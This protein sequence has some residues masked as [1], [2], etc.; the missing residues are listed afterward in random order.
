MAHVPLQADPRDADK[1]GVLTIRAAL[2]RARRHSADGNGAS[3]FGLR[4]FAALAAAL[5]VIGLLAN[6]L[7]TDQLKRRQIADYARTQQ[8]DVKSFEAIGREFRDPKVAVREVA[9]VLNAIGKRPGTLEALL[10]DRGRVIRASGTDESAVGTRDSDERID[11]AIDRGRTHAGHEADASKGTSNFEFV[12]PVELPGG[13]YA[14]EVS[15]DRRVLEGQLSDIRRTLT[16]L[17][18]LALVIGSAV[19]YAVGGRA[20]MRSHRAALQRATLDGLTDLP[21]QRAFHDELPQ[22]VASAERH[23]VPLGLAVLDLDD[24]KYLNDRYGHPRGDAA[25]TSS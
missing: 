4:L 8:A 25:A 24:F 21:N 16:L 15:Y 17:G 7:L 19:F 5:A 2:T 3:A 10:I 11:A 23:R 12:A 9:E 18:V 13:R 20:L 1:Q 22:A 14:F 6:L